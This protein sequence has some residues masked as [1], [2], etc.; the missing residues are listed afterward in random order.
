MSKLMKVT[1]ELYGIMVMMGMVLMM[2]M[3]MMVCGLRA[4]EGILGKVRVKVGLERFKGQVGARKVVGKGRKGC[5]VGGHF[6][7]LSAK[8]IGNLS[9]SLFF[10]RVILFALGL[11]AP[12]TDSPRVNKARVKQNHSPLL[13]VI[14]Y[15]CFRFYV[16]FTSDLLLVF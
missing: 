5:P 16:S 2:M 8:G 3:V 7:K 1:L 11:I 6:L 14:C 15:L 9:L 12:L 13:L 10:L 4:L